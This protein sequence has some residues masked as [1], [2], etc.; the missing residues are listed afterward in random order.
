MIFHDQNFSSQISR[1]D[2]ISSK[3]I[4]IVDDIFKHDFF[5]FIPAPET[6][7]RENKLL[8]ALVGKTEEMI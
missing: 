6:I 8:S 1:R 5:F 7:A 2:S 4:F 3:H